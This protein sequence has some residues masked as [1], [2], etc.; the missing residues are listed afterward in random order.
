VTYGVD[1]LSVRFGPHRALH[2]VTLDVA[3][4]EVA[5]V[6]GGDGAGKSTLL[7]ALVGTVA[8]TEGVVR[9]PPVA[10]IG[11]LASTSGTYPDLSV[12]ENLEFSATAYGLARA[13]ARA[14]AA[15][16]LERTGLA[17]VRGRLA[18]DLSGGMRQKLGVIRAL[19][20]QP[21]LV[22]LD[23]PTTGVD[24]VSR[25]DLWWLIARAAAGG[26]AVVFATTYLDEAERAAQ[27]L[28]L[29]AG[30][31][32]V[33]G[34]PREVIAATPRTVTER[35]H[36]P[37]DDAVTEVLV[38]ASSVTRRFG[39]F[40]AVDDV[41]LDLAA[42]EVVGLL[43]ANGA[44]KT[45]LIRM[46][47]GLVHPTAGDVA[48]FG[49][50]PSLA[51]RRRLGYVPQTL[52]LYEELTPAE[53]LAFTG[54][55]FGGASSRATTGS[56]DFADLPVGV[57][58]LGVKRR[59]AFAAALGHDPDL[60]VLDEPTSGVDP[61]A[62]ARLWDTIHEAAARGVGVLVTTHH[63]EEAEECDRLVVMAGGR[64]VAQ[65]SVPEIV[66]DATV[67]V[68]E[69]EAWPDAFARLEAAGLDPTL[70]GASLRVLGATPEAVTAALGPLPAQV[71]LAPATLDE[72]FFELAALA[73]PERTR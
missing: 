56:E 53:N 61:L 45:T 72:R 12:D 39:T 35:A 5:A 43:G 32:L 6:V 7:R 67:T 19:L 59:V 23:E 71:H 44:G 50:A 18:G 11:F 62:R 42:G 51:T 46:L 31:C 20:H 8:P 27:V 70:V 52:G 38:R 36:R 57:L 63:M 41:D 4:G 26:A 1:D 58:P 25:A 21:D 54:A 48:L 13:D 29:D 28:V 16:Y 47:L 33:A 37:V 24:P 34:T 22:V 10:R 14:R 3:P 9:R 66:G 65:G 40:V 64:V 60:L 55:V 30:E 49:E 73:G 17:E 15:D 68:V 69:T 2:R